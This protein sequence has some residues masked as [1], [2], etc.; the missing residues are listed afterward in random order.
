MFRM[1]KTELNWLFL[2]WPNKHTKKKA[3]CK[4]ELA[5]FKLG[6]WDKI[7]VIFHFQQLRRGQPTP[8]TQQ[9]TGG[10]QAREG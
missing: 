3:D 5:G 9:E 8:W 10:T 4:R 2:P 1:L 6:G 7:T